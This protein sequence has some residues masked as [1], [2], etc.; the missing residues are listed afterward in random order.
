MSI[1]IEGS[2]E[3]IPEALAGDARVIQKPALVKIF[4]CSVDGCRKRYRLK[5]DLK[6]HMST[7]HTQAKPSGSPRSPS[8][9]STSA[10]TPPPSVPA[11]ITALVPMAAVNVTSSEPQTGSVKR[12]YGEAVSQAV[13]GALNSN[14]SDNVLSP[15]TTACTDRLDLSRK[16]A[17]WTHVGRQPIVDADLMEAVDLEPVDLLRHE[18]YW[19]A[20]HEQDIHDKKKQKKPTLSDPYSTP[21]ASADDALSHGHSA[22]GIIMGLKVDL[23]T[24]FFFVRES[25][26]RKMLII[27]NSTQ[28]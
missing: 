27:A 21:R 10:V 25:G 5:G 4:G 17:A 11:P 2:F 15:S 18:D 7:F 9:A 14:I 19:D 12:S 23:F 13:A 3:E 26:L 6:R 20:F 16:V 1:Y 24:L 22:L 8:P 28:C